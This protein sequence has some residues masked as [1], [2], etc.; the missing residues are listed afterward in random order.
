MPLLSSASGRPVRSLLT[1]VV[2]LGATLGLSGRALASPWGQAVDAPTTPS[3]SRQSQE[4]RTAPADEPAPAT[5]S[6]RADDDGTAA[7]WLGDWGRR[8]ELADLGVSLGATAVLDVS[9][10]GRP[11]GRPAFASRVLFDT[12]VEVD[13]GPL[14]GLP[15]LAGFVQ[16]YGKA[17]RNGTDVAADVQG[18][19]NIDAPSFHDLGE[20]WLEVTL[21]GEAVRVKLGRI[22]ANTEFASLHSS[23][24]FVNSSMG[25]SPTI[26]GFP[27]YPDPRRGLV[28]ASAR[29]AWLGVSA[30]VFERTDA[31]PARPGRFERTGWLFMAQARATWEARP[32]LDGTASVGVWRHTGRVDT[33]DGSE[34]HGASGPFVT[35]EQTVWRE[36]GR[37]VGDETSQHLHVFLQYGTASAVVSEVTR[38]VGGGLA[39]RAPSPRRRDDMVGLGAT[40]VR[41]APGAASVPGGSE[42]S[43][44]PFYLARLRPWLAVQPDLQ[45]LVQREPG[46]RAR[47]SPVLTC[48]VEIE[49]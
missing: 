46:R 29:P 6:D 45:W 42:L 1:A 35:A 38:H 19:S 40:H 49:F 21:P 47:V 22:D 15:H 9:R 48:R 3:G 39:L 27:S 17:G 13:F 33:L 44:G 32:G 20:A 43:V 4:P 10:V 28:V 5:S 37:A 2:I 7:G 30:G 23:E 36:R 11:G 14:L 8:R 16:Y 34:R 26:W 18:F 25:F 31:D 12:R 24:Q 41:L